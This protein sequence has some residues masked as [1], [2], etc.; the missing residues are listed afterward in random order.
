MVRCIPASAKKLVQRRSIH[1]IAC[2]DGDYPRPR[3]SA[4]PFIPDRDIHPLANNLKYDPSAR[5][6]GGMN[7]ALASIN[8]SRELARRFPQR[9]H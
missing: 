4:T 7:D 2:S 5:F 9:V 8:A 6:F 3:L 1:S